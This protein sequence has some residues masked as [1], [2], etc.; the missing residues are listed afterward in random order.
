MEVLHLNKESFEKLTSQTEKAVLIDFWAEW[1]GPCQMLGPQLEAL[2]AE[3]DE[4]IIGKVD[5]SEYGDIAVEM[6]VSSIPA[7]FFYRNGKLEKSLIGYMDKDTLAAK[8]GL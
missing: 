8:L 7:L 1:C 3:H 4:L 2:A 5:V 6:G